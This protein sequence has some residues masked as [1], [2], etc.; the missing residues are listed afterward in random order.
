M[1]LHEIKPDQGHM[2]VV[3]T[4]IGN[5]ADLSA[6]AI[7]ILSQVDLVI[8]EDTRWT[9]KLLSAQA[10]TGPRLVT[11]HEH[12]SQRELD[13]IIDKVAEGASAAVVSDAG[14]PG[15]SDPGGRLVDTAYK[16]GIKLVPIPGPSALTTVI[17]VSGFRASPLYFAGFFPRGLSERTAELARWR[18]IGGVVV[19][20]ESPERILAT[21]KFLSEREPDLAVVFGRELTKKFEEVWRGTLQNLLIKLEQTEQIR[22]EIVLALDFPVAGNKPQGIPLAE[23]SELLEWAARG[24]MPRSRVLE[25]AKSFG[26]P[27]SQAYAWTVKEN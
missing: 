8:A 11:C 13:K 4:P 24:K 1:K 16:R 27:R 23:A 17:S 22:G 3:A 18:A 9:R 12:T 6:R 19:L 21:C 15:I 20:F 14:C 10:I 7:A 5:L 26:I 2:Y 25:L